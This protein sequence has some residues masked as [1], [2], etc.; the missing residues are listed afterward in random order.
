MG[1]NI[2]PK[3][4]PP[5]GSNFDHLLPVGGQCYRFAHLWIIEWGLANIHHE[6]IPSGAWSERHDCIWEVL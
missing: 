6:R 4:T 5:L 2:A 1:T 3:H